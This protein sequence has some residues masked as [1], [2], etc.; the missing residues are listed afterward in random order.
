MNDKVKA[1]I[2]AYDALKR[3]QKDTYIKPPPPGAAPDEE[4]ANYRQ[5]VRN[6]DELD[7]TYSQRLH[8]YVSDREAAKNAI[9]LAMFKEAGVDLTNLTLA[10]KLLE[11]TE[12]HCEPCADDEYWEEIE[13]F[14]REL[15][16]LLA[17]SK[18][19]VSE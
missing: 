6:R 14:V 13:T 10:A 12:S 4:W 5:L 15:A 2:A 16:A 1:A 3:P 19:R 9:Y 17:L 11:F 8:T 18:E 7:M